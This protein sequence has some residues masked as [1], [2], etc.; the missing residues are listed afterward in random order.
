MIRMDKDLLTALG[1]ELSDAAKEGIKS[2]IE[3]LDALRVYAQRKAERDPR[4]VWSGEEKVGG[5]AMLVSL[6]E[7]TMMQGCYV[8]LN[9]LKQYATAILS[10]VYVELGEEEFFK[11]MMKL[12][13]AVKAA[14]ATKVTH[15]VKGVMQ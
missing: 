10:V 11:F 15:E 7:R 12:A 13:P 4:P 2:V 9:D 8:D 1:G 6:E 3:C 14:A 5:F